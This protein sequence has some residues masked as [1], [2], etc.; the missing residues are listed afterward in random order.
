[1]VMLDD[2]YRC[3]HD[4]GDEHEEQESPA[5]ARL[6]TPMRNDVG[7]AVHHS[8]PGLTRTRAAHDVFRKSSLWNSQILYIRDPPRDRVDN[9]ARLLLAIRRPRLPDRPAIVGPDAVHVPA[10]GR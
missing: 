9:V 7:H 6:V 8:T 3:S 10:I 1:M 5:A 4:G 2:Q